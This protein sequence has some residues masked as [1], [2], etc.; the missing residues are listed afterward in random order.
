MSPMKREEIHEKRGNPYTR[1]KQRANK[2]V[3]LKSFSHR[4][5]NNWNNLAS[6]HVCAE[7]V[8]ICKTRLDKSWISKRLIQYI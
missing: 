4:V 7:S 8:T 5:I 2:T 1:V 3:R 6:E